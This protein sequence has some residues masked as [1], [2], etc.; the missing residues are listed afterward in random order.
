M[1]FDPT[2]LMLGVYDP[3]RLMPWHTMMLLKLCD[4]FLLDELIQK[5]PFQGT[6][7]RRSTEVI[8]ITRSSFIG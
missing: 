3:T 7:G 2:R 5:I 8:K 6:S 4:F 1:I